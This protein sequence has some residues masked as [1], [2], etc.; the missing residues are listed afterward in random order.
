MTKMSESNLKANNL[1]KLTGIPSTTIYGILN[2]RRPE[3]KNIIKIAKSFN[4]SI[5]E[6]LG[7][8]VIK[9][10]W[11]SVAPKYVELSAPELSKN[12]KEFIIQQLQDKQ[13]TKYQLG[14]ES[15]YGEDVI[16]NFLKENTIPEFRHQIKHVLK[17]YVLILTCNYDRKIR[18]R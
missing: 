7:R 8:E 4:C 3:I 18:Q 9:S 5:D 14:R 13:I 12:L 2:N 11:D 1:A 15:G 16:R 10:T 6:I 17:L